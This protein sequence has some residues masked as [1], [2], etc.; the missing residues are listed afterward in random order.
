MKTKKLVF[1]AILTTFALIAFYIESA[2]PPVTPIYGVK[3]GLANVF[4]LFALY[5]LNPYCAAAVLFI[6]IVLGS[7]FAG[8]G[9]AFIYS[10][11]GGVASF[12]LMLLLKR[13]FK[14]DKI[15][16][17]SVL[18]AIVH[19]IAQLFTAVIIMESW[20]ILFYLPVL[21]ISGI[22]AGAFTGI[23]AQI[24][25]VRLKKYIGKFNR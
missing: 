11:V 8:L 17:L 19:N 24:V 18:C 12:A 21:I 15:W 23:C 13:F 1:T 4:T 6:R 9:V 20:Q 16:V 25:F 10:L 22:I 7:I 14:E 5:A 3:L 2:I